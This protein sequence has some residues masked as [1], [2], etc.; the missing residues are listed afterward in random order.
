M[1]YN[2]SGVRRDTDTGGRHCCWRTVSN[3]HPG[4]TRPVGPSDTL[5]SQHADELG[6][7][8]KLRALTSGATR[9]VNGKIL[10]LCCFG[11]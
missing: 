5:V 7:S 6:C 9:P 10:E 4:L 11:N 1:T 3:Q 2:C 8:C